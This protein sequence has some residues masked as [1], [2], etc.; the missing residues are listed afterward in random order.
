M[1]MK[2]LNKQVKT[3]CRHTG[4]CLGAYYSVFQTW[5]CCWRGCACV[6]VTGTIVWSCTIYSKL[7]FTS[8]GSSAACVVIVRYSVGRG[9]GLGVCPRMLQNY[10]HEL[11]VFGC[12]SPPSVDIVAAC[13]P[14]VALVSHAPSRAERPGPQIQF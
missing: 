3:T 2:R 11:L 8:V 6:F 5:S 4:Y 1:R 7:K 9:S 13:F 10:Y 14:V 12:S